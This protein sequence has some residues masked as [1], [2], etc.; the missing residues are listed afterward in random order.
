MNRSAFFT[1]VRAIHGGSL[2]PMQ[3]D[4]Y[5]R[6][7]NEWDRRQWQDP[8]HLAYMLA[9]TYHETAKRIQPVRETLAGTDDEA[10]AILERAWKGGKLP[11]VKTPYWRKNAA[12][13]S[14]LGRGL[15]QVTHEINY[16]KLAEITGIDLVS[17]PHRVME[18]PIALASLFD[19]MGVGIYVPHH[20]LTRYFDADTDDPVGARRIINGQ[21]KAAEIASLHAQFLKAI[22]EGA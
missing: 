3:A 5:E 16:R 7:L 18:W 22:Q 10:I 15:P 8:R 19:G 9:T 2:T 12:G 11:W 13:R 20:N 4:G 17:Q 21:D 6:I 1:A 14:Y